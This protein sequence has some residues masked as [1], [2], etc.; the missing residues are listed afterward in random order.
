MNTAYYGKF[1]GIVMDAN[2]PL[3]LARLRAKV[4]DVSGE[5]PSGWAMPCLAL[6]EGQGVRMVVPA[7]GASVWIEYEHGDPEYPIWSGCFW[8]SRDEVP[9]RLRSDQAA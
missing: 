2:D 6:V 5:N 7:V 8:T 9:V 4:P 1:R 3:G